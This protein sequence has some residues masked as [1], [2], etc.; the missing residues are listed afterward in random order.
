ML[1]ASFI[2]RLLNSDLRNRATR[3]VKSPKIYE[4]D[5]GLAASVAGVDE[6]DA[7]E[8]LRGPLYETFVA[9]NLAAI[10]RAHVPRAELAFWNVQGRHEV[11]FVVRGKKRG[12]AIEVKAATRFEDRDLRSLRAYLESSPTKGAAKTIGI[13]A[14][15]G[16]KTAQLDDALFAVPIATLLA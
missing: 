4:T 13:L 16:E 7:D 9:Q 5:S 8:S 14:Y 6:I 15:Q 2:V 1:E 11:D 12:V 3:L 10:L